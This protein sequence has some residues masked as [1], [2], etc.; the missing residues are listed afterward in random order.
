MSYIVFNPSATTPPLT[1]VSPHYGAKMLAS[2]SAL[3]PP[4]NDW[5][6]TPR[7][8]LGT[9]SSVKFYARS[10]PGSNSLDRFRVGV[11]TVSAIIIPGFQI[12]SGVTDVEAPTN[13]NEY[14]YDLSQYDGQNV[15]IGIRCVSN[16]AI[17]FL[18]DDFSVHS[19]GG[20]IVDNDDPSAPSFV[21]DLKG[22][23]PNPFNPETTIRF[24]T[25]AKGPVAIDIY[26]IK[27]QLVRKLLN[28]TLEAGNHNIVFDGKD[29]NGKFI[30]SGMY[31][32]KMQTGKFSSIR[33]MILMKQLYY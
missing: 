5:V 33:K 7:M 18:V 22:N 6:I 3:N 13:W 12:V 20:Y 19:D 30:A 15:Y 11:C 28:T 10:F 16:S 2:F 1:T 26:N 8:H 17:A 27:G 14:V 31:F 25:A 32:Y 4:N 23:Y 9:D 29:E 21:N 24:S